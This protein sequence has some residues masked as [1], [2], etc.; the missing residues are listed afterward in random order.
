MDNQ[1][2]PIPPPT[3]PQVTPVAE[4]KQPRKISILKTIIVISTLVLFN[5][6]GLILMFT[7]SGWKKWVK[8]LVLIL[9]IP[10]Y[11][12]TYVIWKD[13]FWKFKADPIIEN[14]VEVCDKRCA[15]PS[16]SIE[17]KNCMDTCEKENLNPELYQYSHGDKK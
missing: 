15:P 13:F 2:Q 17:R 10:F 9:C 7:I 6:I 1:T 3:Y 5:P 8:I 4:V 12:R 11:V 14:V 16:G